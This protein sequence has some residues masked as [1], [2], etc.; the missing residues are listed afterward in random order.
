MTYLKELF[1]P[2]TAIENLLY[3]HLLIWV[4][5]LQWKIKT[6]GRSTV[7]R[8]SSAWESMVLMTGL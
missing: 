4:L 6:M 7:F 3:E 2:H 1:I 8:K 5:E